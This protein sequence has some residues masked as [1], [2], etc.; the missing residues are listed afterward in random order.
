MTADRESIDVVNILAPDQGW[1]I[2]ALE[3]VKVRK[4]PSLQLVRA[5]QE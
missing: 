5:A 4:A 1:E 3:R 2:K